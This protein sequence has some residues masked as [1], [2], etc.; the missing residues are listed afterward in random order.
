MAQSRFPVVFLE[1]DET[2]YEFAHV[3]ARGRTPRF[4]IELVDGDR[5]CFTCADDAERFM[6]LHGLT[7]VSDEEMEQVRKD[8][9][10]S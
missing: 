6:G 3:D 9:G 2:D 4:C 8:R 1:L 10:Y 5:F 7:G